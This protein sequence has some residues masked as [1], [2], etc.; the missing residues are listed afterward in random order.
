[1]FTALREFFAHYYQSYNDW[2]FLKTVQINDW[3]ITKR[4]SPQYWLFFMQFTTG[5]CGMLA[6][7]WANFL[8]KSQVH[9]VDQLI[10]LIK[11][12]PQGKPL[13]TLCNHDS[14]CDDPLI[15]GASLPLSYFFRRIQ[16]L[17][18]ALGAKEICFTSPWHSL[19]FRFG[20]VLPI[21]RGN[22]IFQPVMDHILE[23]LNKGKWLHI[24]PEGKIN[25]E[26]EQLR[27]KWGVG[28]LIA[29]AI[30]TP[31]VLPFYH[32]GMDTILSNYPPY[33]P[34]TNKKTTIVYGEPIYFDEII[35]NLKAAQ[36]SAEEI[37]KT[38]T[39]IIQT[40]FYKLQLKSEKLHMMHLAGQ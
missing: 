23:E 12:R 26:K 40:E 9:N 35:K 25:M 22:G 21:V 29:D 37:R 19:L 1:M 30:N 6:K 16:E 8:N 13:I 20:Q 31:I 34:R 10:K 2:Y 3:I 28:R 11:E 14:C 7:F 27:L 33:I 4:F 18:W 5:I 15:F 17:R 24:F 32:F 39:D 36:K 38:V